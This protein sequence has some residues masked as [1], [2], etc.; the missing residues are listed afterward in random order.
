MKHNKITNLVDGSTLTDAVTDRQLQLQQTPIQLSIDEQLNRLNTSRSPILVAHTVGTLRFN[1]YGI[2]ILLKTHQDRAATVT[3]ISLLIQQIIP[4]YTSRGALPRQADDALRPTVCDITPNKFDQEPFS[5][6]H[7]YIVYT[8]L[9][10]DEGRYN[11]K[12]YQLNY[13]VI[14]PDFGNYDLEWTDP[15]LNSLIRT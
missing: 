2:A 1:N 11:R 15:E 12:E 7:P 10:G 6:S 4:P 14:N 5:Y 9:R 8:R 13:I 3:P